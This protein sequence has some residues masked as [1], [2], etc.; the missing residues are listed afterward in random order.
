MRPGLHWKHWPLAVKGGVV[1][2]AS[3]AMLL[4]S[5][6]TSHKLERQ[7]ADATAEM[8]RTLKVQRDIQLLHALIAEAATGVRGYLLTGV[9]DFLA[10][11]RIAEARLPAAMASLQENVRDPEQLARLQRLLPLVRHKLAGLNTLRKQ[12]GTETGDL[13]ASLVAGRQILNQLRDGIGVMNAREAVLVEARTAAVQEALRRHFLMNAAT[14]GVGLAGA[15]AMLLFTIRVVRR[16][17]L[18]AEN[19]ERLVNDQPLIAA[20]AANDELGRLAERLHR[21]SLLLANR[22]T[23]ARAASLAKTEFLSRT[24]HELRTPLNAI[25]GFAQ[26][27][28]SGAA[29][30]QNKQHAAH[31]IGAGQHLLSLIDD[32]LDVG[33]IEAGQLP[34]ASAPVPLA[35]VLQEALT[36]LKPLAAQYQVQLPAPDYCGGLAVL[37]DRQRLMQVMLNLLSN[38]IKYNA[39]GG[40][41]RVAVSAQPAA[42]NGGAPASVAIAIEDDGA[43]IPADRQERLFTPFDRLGAEG[44]KTDGIGLGLAVSRSLADA[45]GGSIAAANLPAKGSVFTLRLPRA[46]PAGPQAE[47]AV[48]PPP[49]AISVQ[50]AQRPAVLCVDGDASTLALMET[51]MAR[52]P[53]WDLSTARSADVGWTLALQ[54]KPAVLLLDMSLAGAG[55]MLARWRGGPALA[56]VPVVA[57]GMAAAPGTDGQLKKPLDLPEFFALLDRIKG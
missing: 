50:Q 42:Q 36:L 52:R 37:A 12:Y 38:A 10:P 31:I 14:V 54:R 9:D 22:A 46:A 6:A 56:A 41:V 29:N 26:L 5:V 11:Y 27:L 47:P 23:A 7:S 44:G 51:L 57:L 25:L 55:A 45:M 16:V 48:A 34:M 1:I 49:P 15:L 21:A 35:P 17:R 40:Q 24:S 32:V 3:L 33:R 18:A 39:A 2:A 53:G 43:G 8:L 28:E 19:A 20:G 4:G 30:H 13:R